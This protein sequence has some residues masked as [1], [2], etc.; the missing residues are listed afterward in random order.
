MSV[1]IE[2]S[3]PVFSPAIYCKWVGFLG[4]TGPAP[5]P[6]PT[7]YNVRRPRIAWPPFKLT[8]TRTRRHFGDRK[9]LQSSTR[10]KLGFQYFI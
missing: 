1:L 6:A 4:P 3:Q 9:K 5:L 10:M 7:L 2:P 8:V